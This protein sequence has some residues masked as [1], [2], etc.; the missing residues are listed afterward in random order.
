[1]CP[2]ALG[3]LL[4]TTAA[5][6]ASITAVAGNYTFSSVAISC[7]AGTSNVGSGVVLG[8][9]SDVKAGWA[10]PLGTSSLV[11]DITLCNAAGSYCPGFVGAQLVLTSPSTFTSY[12]ACP[13]TFAPCMR[14]DASA[15]LFRRRAGHVLE[16]RCRDGLPRGHDERC[17]RVQHRRMH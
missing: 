8:D 7:P 16:Q 17:Q 6:M 10:L 12:S 2:G 4:P 5:V 14:A 9:C 3:V 11:S 1:M 15:L 13:R